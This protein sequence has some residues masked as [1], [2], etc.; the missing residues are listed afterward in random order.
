MLGFLQNLGAGGVHSIFLWR[1]HHE[2][3]VLDSGKF[4]AIKMNAVCCMSRDKYMF[5]I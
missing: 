2:L 4:I 3:L 1:M 5:Q